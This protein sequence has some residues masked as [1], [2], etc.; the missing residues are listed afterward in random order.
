[1]GDVYT[2]YTYDYVKLHSDGTKNYSTVIK[3][4]GR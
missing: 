2:H 3:I 1:M 4:G